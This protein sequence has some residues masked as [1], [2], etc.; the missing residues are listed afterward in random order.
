VIGSEAGIENEAASAKVYKVCNKNTP[1]PIGI[2]V[3][4]SSIIEI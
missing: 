1:K 2:G 3:F 4:V